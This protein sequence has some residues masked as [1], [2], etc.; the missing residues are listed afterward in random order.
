MGSWKDGMPILL[1][2]F[3]VAVFGAVSLVNKYVFQ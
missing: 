1:H 2:Y 3:T